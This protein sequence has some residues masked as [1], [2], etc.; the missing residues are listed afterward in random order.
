MMW[1][2]K[3]WFYRWSVRNLWPHVNHQRSLVTL[4]ED[5]VHKEAHHDVSSASSERGVA[6]ERNLPAGDDAGGS[7][8]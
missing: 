3:K 6:Q 7:K 8:T 4:S 2:D 5:I 1:A